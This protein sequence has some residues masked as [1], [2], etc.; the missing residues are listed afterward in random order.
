M[1]SVKGRPKAISDKAQRLIV[2]YAVN[3]D[4][5]RDKLAAILRSEISKNGERPPAEETL[6][7]KISEARNR[8]SSLDQPWSLRSIR[9]NKGN[10]ESYQFS[11]ESIPYILKVQTVSGDTG[12]VTIRQA[13]WIS[14]LYPVINDI[15][16][17]AQVSGRYARYERIC[18][19]SNTPFDTSEFD[20]A[21]ADEKGQERVKELFDKKLE[22]VEHLDLKGL[23]EIARGKS[24][25]IDINVSMFYVLKDKVYALMKGEG[26]INKHIPLP[27]NT[28]EFVQELISH[29]LV[30]KIQRIPDENIKIIVLNK[31]VSIEM[32]SDKLAE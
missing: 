4:L 21:L 23:D 5:R 29:G 6:K 28:E 31:P 8:T 13:L 9:D 7:R 12:P 25:R 15:Q 30:R 10:K 2:N 14:C 20:A 1:V 27:V 19:I 26:N 3:T 16:L 17:L 18:E 11:P 32:P 22:S 24:P